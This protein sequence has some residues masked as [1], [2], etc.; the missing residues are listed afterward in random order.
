MKKRGSHLERCVGTA[1]KEL[2]Q[3]ETC[4][5]DS[6]KNKKK[7]IV[8]SKTFYTK[9]V[10]CCKLLAPVVSLKRRFHGRNNQR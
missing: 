10:M 6:K 3:N 7:K 8:I 2:S 4:M 5:S 1:L 9:K